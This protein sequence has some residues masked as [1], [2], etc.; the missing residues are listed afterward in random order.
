MAIGIVVAGELTDRRYTGRS[1]KE[2]EE[3]RAAESPQSDIIVEDDGDSQ[4]G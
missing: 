1:E 3:G 4:F 2:E